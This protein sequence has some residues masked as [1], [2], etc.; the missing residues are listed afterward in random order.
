MKLFQ[1]IFTDDIQIIC[2][3]KQK[4]FPHLAL[5]RYEIFRSPHPEGKLFRISWTPGQKW[6]MSR[7][8]DDQQLREKLQLQHSLYFE[9]K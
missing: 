1:N 8:Q 5:L 6:M 7:A 4:Q 2:D 9:I 3:E